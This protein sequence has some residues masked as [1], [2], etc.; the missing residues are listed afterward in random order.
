MSEPAKKQCGAGRTYRRV[1]AWNLAPPCKNVWQK[2]ACLDPFC[3]LYIDSSALCLVTLMVAI[4][5][6]ISQYMQFLYLCNTILSSFQLLA[7]NVSLILIHR[8]IVWYIFCMIMTFILSPALVTNM[9]TQRIQSEEPIKI[10]FN[11]TLESIIGGR[12][13]AYAQALWSYVCP[14]SH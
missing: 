2:R 3:H 9:F 7:I 10:D 4:G 13:D 12:R 14:W 1:Q 5:M 8:I 11:S 6:L